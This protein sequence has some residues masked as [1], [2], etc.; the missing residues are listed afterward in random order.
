M[1]KILTVIL[2]LSF[3]SVSAVPR[4]I[5]NVVFEGAGVK[6]IAYVGVLKALSD[7]GWLSD[8]KHI[9]GTSSGAIVSSLYAVGYSPDEIK[10]LMQTT[11][12]KSFNDG[13][14]SF[15]GGLLRLQK[16][17]GWYKGQ[18]FLTWIEDRIEKKL[19]SRDITFSQLA[20]LNKIDLCVTGTN[21]TLQRTEYFNKKNFPDMRVADAV[22]IS[23][24]IPMYYEALFM[25]NTG[26]LH[27]E[28]DTAITINVMVDGGLAANFPIAMFDSVKRNGKRWYNPYT[29]AIKI[30]DTL[31]KSYN[32]GHMGLAPHEIG[33]FSDFVG[34]LYDYT[35]GSINSLPL[36]EPDWD[37]T[38]SINSAGISSRVRALPE[39]ELKTLYQNGYDAV[40]EKYPIANRPKPNSKSRRR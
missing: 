21:L 37:R 3:F 23:M 16:K 15:V 25:D 19:G 13:K 20:F 1:K 17:F 35:M 39:E 12:F 14:Y 38:I 8:V 24:A 2:C 7:S 6:G 5:K 34:A 11:Q 22:R 10:D 29:L 26:K 40:L 32:D 4:Q 27:E 30:E 18:E 31:Q 33:S 28:P 9:G 36:E